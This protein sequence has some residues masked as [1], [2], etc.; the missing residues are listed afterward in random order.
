MHPEAIPASHLHADARPIRTIWAVTP[1]FNRP[2]EVST[3]LRDLA[4]VERPAGWAL[5]VIVIDNASAKPLREVGVPA[6]LQ[7]THVRLDANRGGSGGFSA[8]VALAVHH[9][10]T[11]DDLIWL[12]DSDVRL[13]R[14]SLRPLVEAIVADAGVTAAGSALVDPESGFVFEVGG[15]I[16][17][18]TGELRQYSLRD[19]PGTGLGPR[20]VPYVAACSMLVRVSAAARTGVLPDVFL[21]GDDV[22]WSLRLARATGGRIVSVP[23]SRVRHPHPDRLRTIARYYAARNAP[24]V[25]HESRSGRWAIIAR[26]MRETA[27]ALG[28]TLIG[29]DDLARLH[30]DGLRDASDGLVSGQA[31]RALVIEPWKPLT[32]LK[33]ALETTADGRGSLG[34]LMCLEGALR[35]RVL[36]SLLE[37]RAKVTI[38]ARVRGGPRPAAALLRAL[39]GPRHD[40]AIVSARGRP[41]DWRRARVTISVSEQGFASRS[42][43]RAALVWRLA[44]VTAKGAGYALRLAAAG[45]AAAPRTPS[46]DEILPWVR[47]VSGEALPPPR[48]HRPTLSVVIVSFNRRDALRATLAA[49]T[50]E[51][52]AVRAQIIVVDNAS[53]DGSAEMVRRDFPTAI[54]ME[55]GGNLGIEAFNV[56]A[57]RATGETVLILDDDAR[58]APGVLEA[59]LDLLAR[60]PDLAA[61]A[62]HPRS[63]TTNASEW[64][65]AEGF[66][67]VVENWPVMGCGNLIRTQAWRRVGGYEVDFFLYRNDVDCAL[68][69]LAAGLGV[70][71]NP[72]WVVSHDTRADHVKSDRWFE[73]ATRNWVWMCRRHGQGLTRLAGIALGWA[74]AHRLAGLSLRRHAR[75][76]CG[77]WAG[78]SRRPPAMDAVLRGRGGGLARLHSLRLRSRR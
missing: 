65:F 16:D 19:L 35:D 45:S 36:D 31:A 71:C 33:A 10:R 61:V 11:P 56:G 48:L 32:D 15:W 24:G 57:E 64:P 39:L 43:P 52:G 73:L 60:R 2:S 46:F 29:R 74:W 54:I 50:N 78:I 1:C 68:K 9:A 7:V 5:R 23:A 51:P 44:A 76:L 6:G 66:E 20:T 47:E 37:P 67:G 4:R 21:S 27:R 25:L 13:E 28:Q 34:V 75:A 38:D 55:T 59:A 3:L 17:R 69:L 70:C 72:A 18:G 14:G 8:G 40:V 49:L 41:A 53:M 12:L 42:I 62:L 77:A 63:E 22:I 30:L 26:A 58:P